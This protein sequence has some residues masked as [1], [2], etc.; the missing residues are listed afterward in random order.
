METIAS[1][2]AA[3]LTARARGFACATG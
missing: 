2:L 1:L 3:K